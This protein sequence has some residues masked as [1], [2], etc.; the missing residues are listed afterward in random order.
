MVST[1][2]AVLTGFLVWV[3]RA[4]AAV[5]ALP[6]KPAGSPMFGTVVP[7]GITVGAVVFGI[8]YLRRVATDLL[9]E[10]V[11]LAILWTAMRLVLDLVTMAIV[12]GPAKLP[13]AN[14]LEA[15]G[16][17]YLIVPVVIGFGYLLQNRSERSLDAP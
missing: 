7:L 17:T 14:Y 13:V 2:R 15:T 4:L 16:L 10:S 6:L 3:I 8:L 9:A 5:I 11:K 12:R 1:G